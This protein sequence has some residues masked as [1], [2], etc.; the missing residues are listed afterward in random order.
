M[1]NSYCCL[2]IKF[3]LVI[4]KKHTSGIMNQNSK[5]MFLNEPSIKINYISFEFLNT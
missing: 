3:V 1:I 4:M 2:L 5:F